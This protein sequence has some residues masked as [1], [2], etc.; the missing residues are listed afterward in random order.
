MK[1]IL[2]VEDDKV[3]G[4]CLHDLLI[5]SGYR[6][7]H[8][9][10]GEAALTSLGI[11]TYDLL[12]VD[13]YMPGIDGIELVRKVRELLSSGGPPVILVTAGNVT[14]IAEEVTTL[15]DASVVQKPFEFSQILSALNAAV[16]A[17]DAPRMLG[18][19]P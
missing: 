16:G 9:L 13:V 12:I 15:G 8:V 19:S 4:Q 3:T 17:A 18:S 10:N 14:R 2:V 11:K 1:S 6:A 7:D 5:A